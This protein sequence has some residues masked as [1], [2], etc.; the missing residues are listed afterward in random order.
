MHNV[1]KVQ[2]SDTTMLSNAKMFATKLY[3]EI[4]TWRKCHEKQ[5][6]VTK[7]KH[8]AQRIHKKTT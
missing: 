4:P 6:P 2:V 1:Q 7:E 8:H 3:C 5:V